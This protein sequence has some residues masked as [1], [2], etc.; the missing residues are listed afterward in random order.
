MVNS[1]KDRSG[2][3]TVLDIINWGDAYFKKCGI[4]SPR[5]NIE[6]L[7]AKVFDCKRLDL[8][9]TFDKPLNKKELDVVKKLVKQ[10]KDGRPLQYI[11]S[12]VDFCD[13]V[14]KVCEG[15]LI[16]RPE[17]EILVESLID[18]LSANKSS[19]ELVILDIGT[20]SGNIAIAIAKK[21][22]KCK[23]F[24]V[25][26]SEKAL[27][28]AKENAVANGVE[29]K[30]CFFRADIMKDWARKS[31]MKFD[32]IVSNPPYVPL[33]DRKTLS[34]DV[35]DYEPNEALF[36]GEDGLDFYKRIISYFSEWIK[37]GGRIF[38]ELGINQSEPVKKMLTDAGFFDINLVDDY[39]NI[40]RVVYATK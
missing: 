19:E 6:Y 26:F 34:R 16:P 31:D 37:K 23:M 40:K 14:L 12:E 15:V 20:G 1:I 24:A 21:I 38:L 35:L 32:C 4:E 29:D 13:T 27:N 9:L 33:S 28:V 25:D 8:Y 5:L 39:Q 7:L 17:T 10:R 22:E 2:V 36:G 18:V 11:L 30:I 3:W